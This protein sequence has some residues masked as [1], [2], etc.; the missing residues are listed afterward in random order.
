MQTTK[1]NPINRFRGGLYAWGT[2]K[3][4][5]S[6][7][8]LGLGNNINQP[9]PIQVDHNHWKQISAGQVYVL[10]IQ[11]NDSL[12]F[13]GAHKNKPKQVEPGTTWNQAS[14]AYNHIAAIKTDGSL[15]TWGKHK[16]KPEQ[17][18]TDK[19]KQVST[20]YDYTLAIRDD[21]TLWAW[22][23]NEKGEL[24]LGD[25]LNRTVPTQVGTHKWTQIS[26]G[27][28]HTV[29]VRD[30]GSL[31]AWGD[32]SCEQLG[33][34]DDY[35]NTEIINTPKQITQGTTWKQ[36]SVSDHTLAIKDDGSLWAWGWN[37]NGQLGLGTSDSNFYNKPEQVATGTTWRQVSAGFI[38]TLAIQ[39]NGSLWT[40][41]NTRSPELGLWHTDYI[42]DKP[43]QI[44][45]TCISWK[46]VS[47]GWDCSFAIQE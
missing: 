45:A 42:S 34:G 2:N 16:N 6:E 21:D 3:E 41:G 38:H 46:Q 7:G 10:A 12:W 14:G 17:I 19:W 47:A 15:W 43:K 23:N 22:G 26:A 32:N 4:I 24:G 11:N 13:W 27:S 30:N 9:T 18:G 28:D 35:T 5:E 8:Q 33:L 29:A 37:R 25:T 20:G 44:V 39:D 31:W 40:W 1:I 36:V